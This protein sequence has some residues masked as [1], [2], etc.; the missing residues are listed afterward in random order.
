M[1]RES[2][3]HK[4]SSFIFYFILFIYL[5]LLFF[6]SLPFYCVCIFNRDMLDR[7]R[8]GYF[9]FL[10]LFAIIFLHEEYVGFIH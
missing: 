8:N 10:F 3:L 5:L 1:M 9:L 2:W 6:F 7:F 4:Y